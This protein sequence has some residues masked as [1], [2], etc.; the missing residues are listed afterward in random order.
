MIQLVFAP[1]VL[2]AAGLAPAA[3][4][5]ATSP[6]ATLQ[7]ANAVLKKLLGDKPLAWSG[8]QDARR[9]KARKIIEGFVDFTE[10]SRQAL[11][12]HW[13][14]LSAGQQTDFAGTLR[15]IIVR[16]YVEQSHGAPHVNLRFGDVVMADTK[17]TVRAT[18]VTRAKAG[19]D[20]T[21]AKTKTVTLSLAYQMHWRDGR[22]AAY[23]VVTDD[24]SMVEN[25]QAQFIKIIRK[26]GFDALLDRMKKKLEARPS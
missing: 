6:L 2:L 5:S 14:T 12:R 24:Q 1:L 25:Y 3:S 11:G 8:G 19:A 13:T 18:L 21:G 4:A 20:K 23:D 10:M 7:T 17:A 16:N 26:Q 15:E 22:W 9:A